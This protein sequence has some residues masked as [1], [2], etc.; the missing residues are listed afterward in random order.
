MLSSETLFLLMFFFSR[1]YKDNIAFSF[2]EEML[3]C[4]YYIMYTND[5]LKYV[6][7]AFMLPLDMAYDSNYYIILYY[8]S[9]IFISIIFIE[10]CNMYYFFSIK[11]SRQIFM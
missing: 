4:Y 3:L 6:N 1:S 11:S 7:C 9:N 2:L 5:F 8:I 10:L